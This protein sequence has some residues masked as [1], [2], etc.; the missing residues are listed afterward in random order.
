MLIRMKS[1]HTEEVLAEV[2]LALVARGIAERIKES[3][4]ELALNAESH[5]GIGACAGIEL[6]TLEPKKE[7]AMVRFIRTK[8]SR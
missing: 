4:D 7:A 2:A 5:G 8:R 6:S 1:G 3:A